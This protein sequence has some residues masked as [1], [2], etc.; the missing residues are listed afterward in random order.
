M[1]PVA[2]ETFTPP[3]HT[4]NLCILCMSVCASELFTPPNPS[5]MQVNHSHLP[6]RRLIASENRLFTA[7]LFTIQLHSRLTPHHALT[8]QRAT[9]R[10]PP[11]IRGRRARVGHPQW[12]S[13][14]PT[15]YRS[16]SRF[17]TRPIDP[18]TDPPWLNGLVPRTSNPKH[19]SSRP[20]RPMRCST[21]CST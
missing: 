14:K 21:S 10:H 15:I 6:T 12:P 19:L 16:V 8:R 11:T 17:P 2:S 9:Y 20:P 1:H 13:P 18:R 4:V 3:L 7:L 5:P